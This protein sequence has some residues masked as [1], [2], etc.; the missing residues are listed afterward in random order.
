VFVGNPDGFLADDSPLDPEA[1]RA[2]YGELPLGF[3]LMR[4][5]AYFTQWESVM[6]M[7][8]ETDVLADCPRR[9]ARRF[10]PRLGLRLLD[11]PF[12]PFRF[13]VQAVRRAQAPD[14]GIDWLL[15]RLKQALA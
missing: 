6:L 3:E 14:P 7:V 4:V 1:L 11:P 5:H 9:L 2:S 13:T 15:D 10:A 12:P 8:S